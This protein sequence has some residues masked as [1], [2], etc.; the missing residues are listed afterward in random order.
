[1]LVACAER[2][3]P[4]QIT[5]PP[6]EPRSAPPMT[7]VDA[8]GQLPEDL[9]DWRDSERTPVLSAERLL[10]PQWLDGPLHNLDR[11]VPVSGGLGVFT[12][13]TRFGQMQT[14][15]RELLQ[16]RLVELA[17]IEKLAEQSRFRTFVDATGE[18]ASRTGQAV[19]NVVTDPVGTAQG[20]PSG[21]AR[22]FRQGY[23]S[24]RRTTL[25]AAD[26][27]RLE[28]KDDEQGDASPAPDNDETAAADDA[29]QSPAE[30]TA[31][32]LIGYQSA[33]RELARRLEVDP[34]TTNPLLSAQLDELA[35]SGLAGRA[36]FGV[37]LG[38]TGALAEVASVTGRLNRL[39]WELTPMQIRDHNER[40]LR[41]AGFSG[42][43]ARAFLRNGAF[44]PSLQLDFC[45][46]IA[47]LAQVDGRWALIEL[48]TE[49]Q[50]EVEARFLV[51]FLHMLLQYQRDTG[52]VVTAIETGA[53]MLWARTSA[54]GVVLLAPVD[55]LSATP[56]LESL[57]ADP[58][59]Q[60]QAARQPRI[61]V[62]GL[63]SPA[64]TTLL[65]R[66]GWTIESGLGLGRPR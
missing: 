2:T 65:Q 11:R 61:R 27:A 53:E 29:S 34:H 60:R 33:R 7:A 58:Q 31:L 15:G 4:D 37:A 40:V 30:R 24:L 8:A 64:A 26:A 63:V 35:W 49:A 41:D 6:V 45:A 42:L 13:E 19:A 48:A 28:R 54:G 1:M 10:D 17:A 16:I 57:V 44:H 20:L 14:E 52:A 59:W 25:D 21:V 50:D 9:A 3:R 55:Y 39:V 43:Q 46:A 66:N 5:L 51:N 38:A 18:A 62:A 36:G 32:R 12:V 22:F 47:E 56:W 23:R